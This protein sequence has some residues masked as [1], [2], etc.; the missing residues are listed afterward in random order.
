MPTS[1]PVESKQLFVWMILYWKPR[2]IHWS[3]LQFQLG[4]GVTYSTQKNQM[5][6]KKNQPFKWPEHF[7]GFH[8]GYIFH[9]LM[10]RVITLRFPPVKGA[11]LERGI[12]VG[13]GEIVGCQ[14]ERFWPRE[15]ERMFPEKG[16]F[17]KERIVFQLLFFTRYI[18]FDIIYSYSCSMK[19]ENLMN[20]P[21]LVAS[22]GYF[23]SF[24]TMIIR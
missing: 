22:L 23:W 7:N 12:R 9:P 19:W 1:Q 15:H 21:E 8:W 5:E 4:R 13:S 2:D 17:Q 11:H 16:P 24:L 10:S 18:H 20:Q 6:F 3:S 14:G